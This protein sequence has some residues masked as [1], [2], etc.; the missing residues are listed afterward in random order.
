MGSLT[1]PIVT[2]AL[3]GAIQVPPYDV[4]PVRADET[5]PGMV[6]ANAP[7]TWLSLRPGYGPVDRFTGNPVA[8]YAVA[9]VT[10]RSDTPVL[11]LISHDARFAVSARV[12]D[13]PP[14]A[15]PRVAQPIRLEARRPWGGAG[16]RLIEGAWVVAA[17]RTLP[18]VASLLIEAN[19]V[20]R[21]DVQVELYDPRLPAPARS[22][23]RN[24][25]SSRA[26]VGLAS[27][28]EREERRTAQLLWTW[29][30]DPLP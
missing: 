3:L 13:A 15:D 7:A 23:A 11:I 12:L 19:G 29:P 10:V 5:V 6:E 28:L 21:P 9:F 1:G 25:G 8:A 16:G 24:W 26:G 17:P 14:W 4:P 30:D 20:G 22:L 2:L 18:R 27:P